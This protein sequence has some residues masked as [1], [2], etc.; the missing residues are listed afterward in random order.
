MFARSCA[1][2]TIARNAC[3]IEYTIYVISKHMCMDIMFYQAG[4]RGSPLQN[5]SNGSYTTLGH[6]MFFTLQTVFP[7]L[8]FHFQFSI[9][10]LIKP[11]ARAIYLRPYKTIYTNRKSR[12]APTGC[13]F[14]LTKCTNKCT[15]L[16]EPRFGALK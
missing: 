16:E 9:L 6:N 7:T 3:K 1:L 10:H 8:I 11:F 2:H 13:N 5:C 15:I 4:E 12:F 14:Y